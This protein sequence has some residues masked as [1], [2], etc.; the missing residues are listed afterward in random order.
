VW[1]AS[2]RLI[3][4]ARFPQFASQIGSPAP[5]FA[6]R[7][8][9]LTATPPPAPEAP[10]SIRKTDEEATAMTIIS[11]ISGGSGDAYAKLVEGLQLE[12]GCSDVGALAAR[13]LEA[14]RSE[15]H[16]D[17]RVEERY[18]GQHLDVG[19]GSD[20]EDAEL[21]RIAILSFLGGRWH[22]GVCLVDGEGC[23]ADLLWL[24]TFDR[25]EDA[26]DAFVRSR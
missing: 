17:A 9:S 18:L 10:S 21:S 25:R 15:F 24:R 16:W 3:K 2:K 6:A 12:F 1:R 5:R 11:A 4:D 23:A 13:I 14:E 8:A 22:A 26:A 20:D 7:S 19:L